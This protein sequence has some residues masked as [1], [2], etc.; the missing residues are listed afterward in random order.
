MGIRLLVHE[1]YDRKITL[2]FL[3]GPN[4]IT[5]IFNVD[6]LSRK[7]DESNGIWRLDSLLLALEIQEE[8]ESRDAD[9]L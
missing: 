6:E 4:V 7:R 5:G 8:Q 3:S 2:D 1:P 9:G